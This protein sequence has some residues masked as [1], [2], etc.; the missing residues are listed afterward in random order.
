MAP[1]PTP[2]P[3]TSSGHAAIRFVLV[4]P[5]HPGNL[6]AS[7][8]ALK[9]MGFADLRVVGRPSL[10]QHPDAV[11]M[12]HGAEEHL[13]RIT[14]TT[15]LSEALE[16]CLWTLGTTR[17]LRKPRAVTHELRGFLDVVRRAPKQRPLAIVFGPE[18]DG[19][20]FEDLSLCQG[21]LTIPTS[22]THPSLNLAQAV[23]LVA[24]E[25]A[26][27]DATDGPGP[28]KDQATHQE[29]EDMYT[30]LQG[31]LRDIGFISPE[32]TRHQMLALRGL[33]SRT[34]PTQREVTQLRGIWR[35]ASWAAQHTGPRKSSGSSGS[36]G[37]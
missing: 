36:A 12:A 29:L 34:Q 7:A 1:D 20:G 2:E 14:W 9:N 25:L 23:L 33:L 24:W 32:T 16:G 8:R 5:E 10:A 37:K 28:Q 35:Q 3:T 17:R 26:P 15:T 22:Q 13:G 31:M 30:H 18:K 19:L 21:T 4:Q 6:G 11:R 27:A